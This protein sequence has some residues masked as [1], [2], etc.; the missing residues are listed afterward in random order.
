MK[1]RDALTQ[2]LKSALEDPRIDIEELPTGELMGTISS[3]SFSCN[4]LAHNIE[5]INSI[6][7]KALPIEQRELVKEILPLSPNEQEILDNFLREQTK[8]LTPS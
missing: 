2:A 7:E 5:L 3:E 4:S 1:L 8:H 6:L